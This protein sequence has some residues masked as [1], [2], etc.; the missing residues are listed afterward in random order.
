MTKYK[1]PSTELAQNS[2]K[3]NVRRRVKDFNLLLVAG[4]DNW[5]FNSYL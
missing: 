2:R 3:E 5:R 1:L 4:I